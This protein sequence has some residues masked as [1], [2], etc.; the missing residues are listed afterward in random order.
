M[1]WDFDIDTIAE[2]IP[3]GY[4]KPIICEGFGFSG[5]GVRL[6]GRVE[7]LVRD[8]TDVDN[9][10][11]IAHNVYIGYGAII[12]AQTGIAGS[13][14]IG[15]NVIIGDNVKIVGQSGVTKSIKANQTINGKPAFNNSDFNKSYVHF[16]NLPKTI[17]KLDTK[18]YL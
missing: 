15:D 14:T 8:S 9:L 10:V 16:K 17:H 2:N 5:I 6:D 3:K 12:A 1:V 7:I 18:D 13:T 11:Q 4:Y